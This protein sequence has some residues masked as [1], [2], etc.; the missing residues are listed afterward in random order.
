MRLVSLAAS[1]TEI[2]WS[3]GCTDWLVGM[4]NHSD[5]PPGLERVERVGPDLEVD[6]DR[7]AALKPD[8]VL[9][10]L[11]VPGMERVVAGL[12]AR[13]LP[14]L[15]LDPESL[16]D[17]YASIRRVAGA[18]GVARRGEAVV[19]GMQAEIAAARARLPAWERPPRVMVEW[20]PRPPI[21]A[22]RRSWVTG[23]LEAL[24]ARNAFAHLDARS[25]PLTDAEI[26]A[27]APDVITVS[28]CGVKRLRPEVVRARTHAIPALR[29]N[30]VY[31]L[32]EAYLGRPGPRL[33]E[34]ARRLAEILEGWPCGSK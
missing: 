14:H 9:A 22:A 12:E 24:G 7:V 8:L 25:A 17:V 31:P 5:F 32:P 18:L 21:A 20:W 13:G 34:G 3:L 6:L 29:Y 16:E 4:D 30:R 27:A 28:W 26:E 33:A 23:L 10:S 1:N 2:V 11:S 19:R 15:V